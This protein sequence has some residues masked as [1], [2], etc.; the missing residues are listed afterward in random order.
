MSDSDDDA[1]IQAVEDL[2]L[3]GPPRRTTRTYSPVY[4]IQGTL[5]ECVPGPA[6]PDE[7]P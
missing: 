4:D 2:L 7:E 1:V 6:I 3:H 5:L